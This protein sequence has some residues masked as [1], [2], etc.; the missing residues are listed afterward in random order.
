M[1]AAPPVAAL[2][3]PLVEPPAGEYV[4][5]VDMTARLPAGA[6]A[7]SRFIYTTGRSRTEAPDPTVATGIPVPG[8]LELPWQSSIYVKVAYV[9]P[10][11]KVSPY[12]VRG[13]RITSEKPPVDPPPVDPPSV[14]PPVEPPPP[15]ADDQTIADLRAR[16]AELERQLTQ[17][18]A[19]NDSQAAVARGF[20]QRAQAAE[21][22]SRRLTNLA[23]QM[24]FDEPPE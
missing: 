18:V 5:V 23:R 3:A 14:E 24:L 17:L 8:E 13:Y 10:A 4:G 19:D 12:T 15:D 21:A 6:P 7:G 11:G 16:I 22:E 9:T 1:A 2:V 20:E